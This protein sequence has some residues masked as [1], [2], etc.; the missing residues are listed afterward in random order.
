M[1]SKPRIKLVPLRSQILVYSSGTKRYTFETS[2]Q[3]LTPV[4]TTRLTPVARSSL[5]TVN[6]LLLIAVCLQFCVVHC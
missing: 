4:H 5:F 6:P 3:M 1:Q 2:R